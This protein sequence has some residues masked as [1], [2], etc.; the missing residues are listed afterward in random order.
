LAG[1]NNKFC[2]YRY[3]DQFVCFRFYSLWRIGLVGLVGS[4]E[5][6][7]MIRMRDWRLWFQFC[8]VCSIQGGSVLFCVQSALY[9]CGKK[10]RVGDSS[11][12]Q[13]SAVILLL[14]PF[15]HTYSDSIRRELEEVGKRF[16]RSIGIYFAFT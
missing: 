10:Q 7:D 11:N 13:N 1:G 4:V 14:I 9:F 8:L 12:I 16:A 6:F 2:W 15:L 3:V 5:M